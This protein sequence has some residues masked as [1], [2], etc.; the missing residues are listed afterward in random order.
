MYVFERE[1]EGSEG[2]GEGEGGSL[3][4]RDSDAGLEIPGP[5]DRDQS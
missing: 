3:V 2:E 5:Q 4:S 1:R